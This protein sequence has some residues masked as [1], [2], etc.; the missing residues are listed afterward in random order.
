[1][2]LRRNSTAVQLSED[3]Y[4]GA[5]HP[6]VFE[7]A[8]LRPGRMVGHAAAMKPEE[9]PPVVRLAVVDEDFRGSAGLGG[10]SEELLTSPSAIGRIWRGVEGRRA[11]TLSAEA[12]E[13]PNGRALTFRWV[14]LRGD[15][16]LVRITPLG[17]RGDAARVEVDWHDP[18]TVPKAPG[19]EERIETSRVDIGVFAENGAH[20]SAPAIL[21]I[22]F[23]AHQRR[24]YGEGLDGPRLVSIDYDAAAREVYFDPFLH[25][26]A[27]WTDTARR[28]AEGHLIGWSRRYADGTSAEIGAELAYAIDRSNQSRPTLRLL[29]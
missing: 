4:S 16:A 11:I 7:G 27:P 24:I 8:M 5:A 29:P 28:D 22:D 1:M 3:Y 14:L 20:P 10:L 12:T 2:I 13:D 21:S 19:S 15:P 9:I 26:T 23:P 17:E 25:W 18:F 6:T